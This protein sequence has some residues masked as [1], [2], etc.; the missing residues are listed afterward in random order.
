MSEATYS[1][2]LARYHDRFDMKKFPESL[3]RQTSILDS[4]GCLLAGS[5]L[6]AA[7]GYGLAVAT[8]GANSIS[9]LVGSDRRVSFPDAVQAMS[10][11]S[12]CG[13]MDDIHGGAGTCIAP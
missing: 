8:S 2:K 10:V 6:E 7:A 3:R 13:E 11:A 4:L 9:S 12:H 1:E 5:R